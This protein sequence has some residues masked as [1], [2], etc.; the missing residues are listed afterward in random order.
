MVE[1][2]PPGCQRLRPARWRARTPDH[3]GL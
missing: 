1:E 3:D 2:S